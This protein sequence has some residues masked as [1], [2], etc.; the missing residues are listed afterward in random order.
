MSATNVILFKLCKRRI[1]PETKGCDAI[2]AKEPI[3]NAAESTIGLVR[4]W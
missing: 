1:A 2:R 4:R 3:G